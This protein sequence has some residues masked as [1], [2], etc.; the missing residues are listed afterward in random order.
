MKTC[1]KGL[2][3]YDSALKQCPECQQ[4]VKAT[5]A[6]ANPEKCVAWVAKWYKANPEKQAAANTT[7]RKANPGKRNA[8][9][10]KRHAAK[11]QRTP[12]WADLKVIR[13]FYINCPIGYEVDHIVPLQ[14]ENVS[15]FHVLE[16]LQYLTKSE[17]C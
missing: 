12:K 14:G 17:N 5:W 8:T 6:K 13:Q 9:Q 16:N 10:A 1:R 11:L 7:W 3:Q 15:G 2:H 4:I